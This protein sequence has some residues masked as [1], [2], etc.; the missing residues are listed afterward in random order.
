M[1]DDLSNYFELTAQVIPVLLLALVIESGFLPQL[2]QQIA[3][4]AT[5]I[6]VTGPAEGSFGQDVLTGLGITADQLRAGPHRK[7]HARASLHTAGDGEE[8]RAEFLALEALSF[9][10]GLATLAIDATLFVGVLCEAI[11]LACVAFDVPRFWEELFGIVVLV[12]TAALLVLTLLA[13]RKL[14]VTHAKTV[15]HV[16]AHNGSPETDGLGNGP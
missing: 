15:T 14:T 8:I 13:L 9:R 5:R 2:R 4:P 1:A 3:P 7:G 12:G 16:K 10:S 11:A 6:I